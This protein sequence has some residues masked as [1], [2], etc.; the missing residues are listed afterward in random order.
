MMNAGLSRVSMHE[1]ILLLRAGTEQ[2]ETNL[3]LYYE[4]VAREDEK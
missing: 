2:K 3:V 4:Q 1:I